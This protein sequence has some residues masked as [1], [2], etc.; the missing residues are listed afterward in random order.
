MVGFLTDFYSVT[1]S[2]A[3]TAMAEVLHLFLPSRSTEPSNLCLYTIHPD[4]LTSLN[5][6][7]HLCLRIS[8]NKGA[9]QAPRF[10]LSIMF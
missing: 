10:H 5:Y 1:N 3:L 4:E 6:E 2:P 9:K 7:H 8:I